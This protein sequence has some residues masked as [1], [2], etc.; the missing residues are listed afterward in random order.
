ME[1]KRKVFLCTVAL[2]LAC[3]VL[4]ILLNSSDIY[5][6]SQKVIP[7]F[8]RKNEDFLK[9]PEKDC[10]KNTPFLVILVTSRLDDVKARMAIRKTW[11]KERVIDDKLVVTY[12]L[13]GTNLE[14]HDQIIVITENILYNDIIQKDFLDTYNN[15]TLKTLMGLE[16]IHKFCPQSTFVM[17]TDSD[18]FVNPYYLIELLLKRN[19]TTGLFTGAINMHAY[20]IRDP[21][22]KWYVNEME[23]PGQNY[24][25][26]CSGTGYVL[27]T[28]V[29]RQVHIVSKRVPFLKL[30]DVFVALCLSE[31]KI[32]PEELHSEPVF[33]AS[34]VP[35][36]PCR[37]MNIVTSHH[38]TPQQ[39]LFTMEEECPDGVGSNNSRLDL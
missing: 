15:L 33:F 1:S 23:Y 4:S 25:P 24:P 37:Y 9:L 30:E 10:S 11:G 14:T 17:K 39:I 27:S 22:S 31:L 7:I 32:V 28:D 34:Q 19:S 35:F 6:S 36:S 21:N 38:N 29:A 12:F 13:L 20:P 16:W 8:K 18:M 26:F 3:F 2:A 5:P